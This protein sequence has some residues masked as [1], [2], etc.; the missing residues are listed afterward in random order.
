MTRLG[1]IFKYIA[2]PVVLVLASIAWMRNDGRRHAVYAA[3][4]SISAAAVA[5]RVP[6]FCW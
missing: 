1:F 5:F 2:A 3:L 4:L 6:A